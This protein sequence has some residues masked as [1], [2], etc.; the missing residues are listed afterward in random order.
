MDTLFQRGQRWRRGSW[1][2]KANWLSAST[3]SRKR[4]IHARIAEEEAQPAVLRAD[5]PDP[6]CPP[7]PDAEARSRGPVEAAEV[8]DSVVPGS[9]RH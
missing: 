1:L 4:K 8:E 6:Y 5:P 3:G 7:P 2:L 9:T